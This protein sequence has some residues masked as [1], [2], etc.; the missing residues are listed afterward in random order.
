M[1]KAAQ[2]VSGLFVAALV[3]AIANGGK[4]SSDLP[5]SQTAFLAR[6][7]QEAAAVDKARQTGNDIAIKEA[8]SSANAFLQHTSHHADHWCATVATVSEHNGEVWLEAEESRLTFRMRIAD[9]AVKPWA[10]S[11]QRGDRLEFSGNLG[12]ER[13]L[14][15]EGG[16]SRPEF[17]FWPQA[18][19]LT[20]ETVE[21]QQSAE[22]LKEATKKEAQRIFDEYA[23]I[24]VAEACQ[25][26][27]R[28]RLAL[29]HQA[30][31]S[32]LKQ[33]VKKTGQDIW[34][35]V[36][37]VDA[38]NRIGA[39]ITKRFLCN[40]KVVPGKTGKPEAT[41]KAFAFDDQL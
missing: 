29:P 20:S 4:G 7:K 30:D 19:R 32:W 22:V 11:R 17:T 9:P 23:Q 21:Q 39:T 40:V 18:L 38:K 5:A 35:Y 2:V 28:A 15:L 1:K 6:V 27:A 14:S 34:T 24:A 3:I 37:E 16:L 36:S 33:G 26:A 31:F 10:S 41:V 13:S 25:G 12:P 8:K